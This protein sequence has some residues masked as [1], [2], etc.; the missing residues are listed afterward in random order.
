MVTESA[1]KLK[2]GALMNWNADEIISNAMN[3]IN[4]DIA[5]K[6]LGRWGP[7]VVKALQVVMT[8]PAS[9]FTQHTS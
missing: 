8:A 5:G 7:S 1:R 2:E 6:K 4:F 3:R 9:L